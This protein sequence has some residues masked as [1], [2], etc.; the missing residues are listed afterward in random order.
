MPDLPPELVQALAGVRQ[1]RYY[2]GYP[3]PPGGPGMRMGARAMIPSIQ[4]IAN[5]AAPNV[6]MSPAA[7]ANVQGGPSLS[8]FSQPSWNADA[9]AAT[10]RVGTMY[11]SLLAGLLGKGKDRE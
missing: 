6:A 11:T 7:N 10:S 5:P 8:W 1:G 2:G 3:L 4:G 9:L